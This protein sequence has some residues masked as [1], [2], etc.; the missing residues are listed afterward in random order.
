[1]EPCRPP[2]P[3]PTRPEF[4]P[5]PGTCDSHV[6]IFGPHKVFPYAPGRPFTPPDAPKE[7]LRALHELLGVQRAV[8]VQSTAHGTDHSAM[9]DALDSRPEDYRGVAL[10]PPDVTA[11]FVAELSEHGVCG[12]RFHL[13]AH[14]SAPPPV[15]QIEAVLKLVSPFGWHAAFH[16]FGADL[17]A[18]QDFLAAIDGPVV[19][20]HMARVDLRDDAAGECLLR[21]LDRGNVWVKL[22]APERISV[23]AAPFGDAVRFAR[24]LAEHA[25]DRVVW[26]TDYPHPN[27]PGEMVDDGALVDLVPRI[28]P[29]PVVRRKLLVDNP[30]A[31]F[32]F[33][34]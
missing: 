2:K 25:P 3:D 10:V 16:V 18:H 15:E 31:L 22:S 32:G 13:T 17:L 20:D 5:P 1:M 11:S 34:P 27:I 21:L 26:G 23:E 33:R 12:A 6:H 30:S 19:V 7:Q 9:L 8:L 24:A 14:L 29:D 4:V 28:A